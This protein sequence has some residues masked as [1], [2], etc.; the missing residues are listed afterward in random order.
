MRSD[1]AAAALYLGYFGDIALD[2]EVGFEA[3]LGR[4]GVFDAVET[5]HGIAQIL[6][7]HG[8]CLHLTHVFL[9]EMARLVLLQMGGDG[10]EALAYALREL[11]IADLHDVSHIEDLNAQKS[12]EA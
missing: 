5:G 8:R 10:D 11:L 6:R 7:Y 3:G 4:E 2:G 9:Q 1:R 12:H